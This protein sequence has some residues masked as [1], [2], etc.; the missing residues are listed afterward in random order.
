MADPAMVLAP[1]IIPYIDPLVVSDERVPTDVILGCAGVMSEPVS[2]VRFEIP[3]TLR[4]DRI[5]VLV[6]LGCDG[7]I[8]DPVIDVRFEMPVTLSEVKIP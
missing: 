3:V 8:S 2:D 1:A 5:P 7:V 6:I 4:V